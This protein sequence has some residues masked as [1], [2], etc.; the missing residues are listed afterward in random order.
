MTDIV[1]IALLI[2]VVA[3]AVLYLTAKSRIARRPDKPTEESEIILENSE[4]ETDR[5]D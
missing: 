4:D 5:R 2:G 3:V 1:L